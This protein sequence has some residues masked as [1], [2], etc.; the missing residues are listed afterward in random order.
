DKPLQL[1]IL[2]RAKRLGFSDEQLARIRDV[3]LE[4]VYEARMKEN[5]KPVYKL[6]DSCAAVYDSDAPYYYSS[7]EDENESTISEKE[8]V[9]VLGSGPIRIGQGI[10]FDYA[11]VHSILLLKKWVMKQLL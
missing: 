2:K 11:T 8:K 7:Y 9:L 3:D 5:I 1:D 6:V 10:E 4:T